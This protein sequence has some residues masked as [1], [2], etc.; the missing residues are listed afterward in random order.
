[1]T[2]KRCFREQQ[3]NKLKNFS[4]LRDPLGA[5]KYSLFTV[6][7]LHD[8]LKIFNFSTNA[9]CILLSTFKPNPKT[10]NLYGFLFNFK[11]TH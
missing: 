6:S 3:L 8:L 5:Y 7:G 10:L 4:R 9:Y 2:D 11:P 1:M